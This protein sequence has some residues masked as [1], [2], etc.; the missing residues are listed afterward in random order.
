MQTAATL[1]ACLSLATV[2]L[3]VAFVCTSPLADPSLR[4][5]PGAL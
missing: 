5:D 2:A 1:R 4:S 3:R